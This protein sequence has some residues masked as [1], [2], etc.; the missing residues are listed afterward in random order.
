MVDEVR[1]DVPGVRLA[2]GDT[3][4]R[5][6]AGERVGLRRPPAGK[7]GL[8]AAEMPEHAGDG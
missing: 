8:I 2:A 4:G 5:D 7:T 3:T 1:F 6:V